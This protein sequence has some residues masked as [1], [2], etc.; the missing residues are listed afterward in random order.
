MEFRPDGRK[1]ARITRKSAELIG[2]L[3]VGSTYNINEVVK[4]IEESKSKEFYLSHLKKYISSNR[5]RDY[6]KFLVKLEIMSESDGAFALIISPKPTTDSHKVQVLADKARIYLA[7]LLGV[8]PADVPQE[9]TTNAI[10]ILKKGELSTMDQIS[11]SAGITS[12]KDEELFRW[13]LYMLL[14]ETGAALSIRHS[15]VLVGS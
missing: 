9:L 3:R 12:K 15:P 13:A 5:V 4:K 6:L 14:D 7:S 8:S 10:S 2:L 1:Y 11:K